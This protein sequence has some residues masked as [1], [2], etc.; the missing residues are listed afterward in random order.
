[1]VIHTH[2]RTHWHYHKPKWLES[3][4]EQV[5]LSPRI[6]SSSCMKRSRKRSQFSGVPTWWKGIKALSQNVIEAHFGEGKCGF[7]GKHSEH[8]PF[9][10]HEINPFEKRNGCSVK[11]RT[12]RPL[13]RRLSTGPPDNT[14]RSWCWHVRVLFADFH[15]FLPLEDD[16]SF[17]KTVTEEISVKRELL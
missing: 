3:I 2:A 12:W 7:W 15:L 11:R 8:L 4:T 6:L 16:F 5:H 14:K 17:L 10:H 1:M 9:P 13:R